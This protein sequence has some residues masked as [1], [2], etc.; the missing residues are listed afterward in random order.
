MKKGRLVGAALSILPGWV[1]RC[2]GLLALFSVHWTENFAFG[3][4]G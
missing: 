1:S 4:L 3:E 2:R